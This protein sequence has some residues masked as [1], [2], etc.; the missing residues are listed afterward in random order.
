MGLKVGNVL[1]P[2]DEGMYY[3][4]TR[5]FMVHDG[6]LT[7]LWAGDSPHEEEGHVFHPGSLW[8][9]ESIFPSSLGTDLPNFAVYNM[10]MSTYDEESQRRYEGSRG[11]YFYM[12]DPCVGYGFTELSPLEALAY[13]A[14]EDDASQHI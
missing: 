12:Q 10:R 13:A 1:I 4:A 9:V 7:R 5:S 6:R 2:F 14:T 8:R 11:F 3:R